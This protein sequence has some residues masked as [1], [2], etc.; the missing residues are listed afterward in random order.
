M[1]KLICIILAL[2]ALFLSSCGEGEPQMTSFEND[3]Y[4]YTVFDE[5]GFDGGLLKRYDLV[6]KKASIVCPDPL[7]E[8]GE[9]CFARGIVGY[10]VTDKYLFLER[11]SAFDGITLY[12][13]DI[14]NNTSEPLI[15]GT[16]LGEVFMAGKYAF[17]SIGNYEYTDTG[18]LI[19]EFFYAYRY[20]TVKKKLEQVGDE[21]VNGYIR[22]I[23]YSD[24]EIYWS[25]SAGLY[26][27]DYDFVKIRD[28]SYKERDEFVASKNTKNGNRV[29]SEYGVYPESNLPVGGSLHLITLY[30]ENK[31]EKR[32]FYSNGFRFT[33]QKTREGFIY[34]PAEYVVQSVDGRDMLMLKI[35]N[36]LVYVNLY[37]PSETMEW[38]IPKNVSLYVTASAGTCWY[39]GDYTTFEIY[40]Y[41]AENGKE[42]LYA[43]LYVINLKTGEAF[44]IKD[45]TSK[46][47]KK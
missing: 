37:D 47:V 12:I 36:K 46:L 34:R 25:D 27:T 28:W 4:I 7:C 41:E 45:E 35:E 10:T 18:E 23:H 14:G 24:S 44:T 16:Q 33:N 5:A 13:Y 42:C 3:R 1:K 9:G 39:V 6:E 29:D 15:G 32:E 31:G 38:E 11:G 19:G 30:N 22:M 17:F 40:I 21:P 20:D 26:I 8:H 43:G 2:C